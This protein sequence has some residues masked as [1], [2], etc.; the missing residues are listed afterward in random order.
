MV[1]PVLFGEP[2]LGGDKC[3][4]LGVYSALSEPYLLLL[5]SLLQLVELSLT[6]LDFAVLGEIYHIRNHGG[7]GRLVSAS[8]LLELLLLLLEHVEGLDV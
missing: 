8:V 5:D 1:E 2:V 7:L 4:D 3:V 6:L